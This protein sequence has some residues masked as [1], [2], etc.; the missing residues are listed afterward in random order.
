[1]T[2]ITRAP[3]QS[4]VY[5]ALGCRSLSSYPHV[6]VLDQNSIWGKL[7][8]LPEALRDPGPFQEALASADVIFLAGGGYFYSYH[9]YLPGMNY[10]SYCLPAVWGA[11][12]NRKVVFLP[13][14]YGPLESW[15]SRRL[16]AMSLSRAS[17][18]FYRE[19]VSGEWLKKHFPKIVPYT[20]FM[21]DLALYLEGRDL[22]G[23]PVAS[24]GGP[25][26][27]PKIGVTVRPWGKGER[28]RTGYLDVLAEV[29][30]RLQQKYQASIC[31]L[32]QVH[33][34]KAQEGDYPVSVR[35]MEL[36]KTRYKIDR[37][38]LCHTA[39][40]FRLEE[41]FRLYQECDLIIGTRL[42]SALLGFLA[43]CPSVVIG[44]Q[45]KARG[46][47]DSLGLRELYAGEID[48]VRV[49]DLEELCRRAWDQKPVWLKKIDLALSE[50]RSRIR[51]T[52]A[53]TIGTWMA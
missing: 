19:E 45:H 52:A 50:A 32:V 51:D 42:H 17:A 41:L 28:S 33:R 11:R 53:A 8:R 47:L 4:A 37:V 49:Q 40:Y 46:I 14:S 9:P 23:G 3:S 15:L 39:P 35:L 13:Q 27:I 34:P 2:L 12:R 24:Q 44:Y 5:E 6:E 25:G 18:V 29:L 48:T 10:L 1:M 36:L 38:E 30:S 22:L 26:R 43:G 21:P 7:V 20:H 16:L 31:I